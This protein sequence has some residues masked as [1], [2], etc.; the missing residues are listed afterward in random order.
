[1]LFCRP[2]NFSNAFRGNFDCTFAFFWLFYLN[3]KLF[4]V[5][6]CTIVT[7]LVLNYS[8]VP[9]VFSIF[10]LTVVSHILLYYILNHYFVC[11]CIYILNCRCSDVVLALF[12]S[13]T[14]TTF[15]YMLFWR[16]FNCSNG[17]GGMLLGLILVAPIPFCNYFA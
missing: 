11:Q 13:V 15:G 17:S 8:T 9:T 14:L 2:F 6:L 16:R 4:N 7:L 3:I 10:V 1:M 12:S 5:Y